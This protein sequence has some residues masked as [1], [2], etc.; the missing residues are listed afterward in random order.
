MTSTIEALEDAIM[1]K[2]HYWYD[3]QET[4]APQEIGALRAG[5]REAITR[6]EAQSAEPVAWITH[7]VMRNIG[8]GDFG[9]LW[10]KGVREDAVIPLYTRPSPDLAEQLAADKLAKGGAK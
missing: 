7:A 8:N 3:S 1:A 9:M 2:V 10:A 4:G 5:V 6:E